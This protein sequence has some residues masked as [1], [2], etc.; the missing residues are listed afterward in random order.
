MKRIFIII[1]AFTFLFGMVQSQNVDEIINNHI[2]VKGGAEKL[3]SI[4]SVTAVGK[5]VRMNMEMKFSMYYKKPKMTRTEVTFSDKLMVFAYDGETAWQISPFTGIE[6]PQ[7]MTGD[8]A[9]DAKE[10]AEMFENPLINYTKKGHKV[11][12]LGKDELEGT[13]VF[14]VKLT[15]KDGK[16]TIFYFDTETF[17]DLKTE[18][19]RIKK[20]GKE[21]KAESYSSDFKEVNGM[22]TAF[23]I[24]TKVNGMDMGNIVIES[25]KYDEPLEDSFFKMPKKEEE[26]K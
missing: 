18:T 3:E 7:I 25:I 22:M 16:E 14:K 21:I 20:D 2:E 5:M 6:G 15:M 19:T 8:Q 10:T 23:S 24:K 9:D 12:L 1:F 17:I 11:E 4:K 26:K 13:E